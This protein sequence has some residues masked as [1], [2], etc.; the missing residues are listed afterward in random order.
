MEPIQDIRQEM[1]LVRSPHALSQHANRQERQSQTVDLLTALGMARRQALEGV[2]LMMY[3]KALEEFPDEAITL[4]LRRL[5]VKGRD[6]FEPRIPELGHLIEMVRTE[7]R[8][9]DRPRDCEV[10]DNSRLVVVEEGEER[11]AKRCQ[12]FIEWKER[13]EGVGWSNL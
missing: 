2:E 6:E 4:V 3:S 10:C 13:R 8:R 1:G 5:A 12:C 9:M 11:V 7:A